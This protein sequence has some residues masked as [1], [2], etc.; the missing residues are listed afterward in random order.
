MHLLDW[1]R[2][3]R[4]FVPSRTKMSQVLPTFGKKALWV[5]IISSPLVAM[6]AVVCYT[7]PQNWLPK[8]REAESLLGIL[9]TAQAAIAALTLAVTLFV[10]Q[11]Q[12]PLHA[13]GDDGWFRPVR[14]TPD[15][16][17]TWR[18]KVKVRL[19]DAGG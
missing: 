1:I 9:L 17:V 18:G 15:R 8:T 10:M 3:S 4:R 7:P 19:S 16:I 2:D 12:A 6:A 13:L 14:G 11:G 5:V